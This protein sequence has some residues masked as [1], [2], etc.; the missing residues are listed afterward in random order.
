MWT[1]PPVDWPDPMT[2]KDWAEVDAVPNSWEDLAVW[3]AELHLWEQE[4][5]ALLAK[6]KGQPKTDPPPGSESWPH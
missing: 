4:K 3:E 1:G 5:A 6:Q 2:P